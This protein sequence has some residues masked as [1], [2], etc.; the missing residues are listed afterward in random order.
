MST[1]LPDIPTL[2]AP[3]VV[4]SLNGRKARD[5]MIEPDAAQCAAIARFLDVSAVRKLRFHGILAPLGT[6][7]WEVS[8]TL[9]ATVVQP[10][11]IT[12]APV[13]TRID[14]RVIRR[15]VADWSDP[16]GE[17]VEMPEDDTLE[18]LGSKIDLSAVVTEALALALPDFP[19]AGGVVLS[20]DGALRAAPAGETPLDD[21]AVKPFA[22]LAALRRK[23]DPS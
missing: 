8:G 6:Q 12:L 19:R 3:I 2:A 13:T 16:E 11:A 1:E 10:C 20:E 18:P 5:V 17:E 7:D 9:G 4:A 15:F 22:G 14:Q 21:D 23:M